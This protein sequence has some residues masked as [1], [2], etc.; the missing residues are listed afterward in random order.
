MKK[1]L[2]GLTFV[3]ISLVFFSACPEPGVSI[4]ETQLDILDNTVWA[5]E[6]PR[7]GDWLTILFL[8][9]GKAV[10]SFSID[11]TSNL[12][13]YTYDKTKK[14]G[15]IDTGLPGFN[16][17]PNGF[18]IKGNTLTIT[19]YGSHAGDPRSFKRYR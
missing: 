18:T 6:T 13:D 11:S 1:I 2:L 17:A 10:F 19:N 3:M 9:E 15:S 4:T 5:G 16:I 14:T 8:P 12:W 7:P